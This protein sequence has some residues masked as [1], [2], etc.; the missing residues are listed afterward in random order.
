M[1]KQDI[2]SRKEIEI[3]INTFYEKVKV[4]DA[5]GYMFASVDWNAHLP[6]MYNFWDNALFY[7]GHYSGNPMEKHQK[8]HAA[9]PMTAAHFKRGLALF[10]A[11][12]NELF[13]GKN[14][15][16]LKERARSIALIMQIKIIGDGMNLK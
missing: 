6:V 11:A 14:A 8:A 2:I 12:I 16:L 5:I 9:N 3:V 1:A 13:S 4:D 10:E 7:T 15:D